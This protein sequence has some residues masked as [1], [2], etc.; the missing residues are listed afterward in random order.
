LGALFIRDFVDPTNIVTIGM[1]HRKALDRVAAKLTA[2]GIPHYQ[3]HE[4]DGDMGF[5]AIATAGI[6]GE[7][8]K[9]FE[10][11]RTWTGEQWGRV[12]GISPDSSVTP[13]PNSDVKQG[14]H[15]DLQM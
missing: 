5:T 1:P 4:P 2:L 8:R 9:A 6:S 14:T 15:P 13:P 10:N 11:Y 3:W 7:T 12:G